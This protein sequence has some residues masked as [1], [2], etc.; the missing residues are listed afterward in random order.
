MSGAPP[1]T[2]RRWFSPV[3][4]RR[5]ELVR[6]WTFGYA[7]AWLV[8]RL[9]YLN[10]LADLPARRFEPVGVLDWM[11]EPPSGP[12]VMG[13][14]VVTLIA[15]AMVALDRAVRV[16]APIGAPG[17]LVLASLTSSYG[18]VFH[19][20]HLLVLHL[21]VLAVGALVEPRLV[22]MARRARGRSI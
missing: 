14:W 13:L 4:A 19:T 18:Q 15:C 11:A 10:D 9:A 3:P 8:V 20:E 16:G 7:A 5:L 22:E 12:L 2:P 1:T 17:M 6:R 21:G